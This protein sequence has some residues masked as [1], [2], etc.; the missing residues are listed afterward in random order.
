MRLLLVIPYYI[1]WHYSRALAGIV[2]LT[3]NLVWFLWHFFSIGLLAKT[4]FSPWQR[5]QEIRPKGL[6]IEAYLSTA[7][8]NMVMRGVGFIIRLLFICLGLIAIVGT[9][10]IGCGVFIVWLALPFVIAFLITY[11]FILLFRTS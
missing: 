2:R 11:G 8:V 4:L 5:L 7:L 3:N 9:I 10:L 1:S 6:D